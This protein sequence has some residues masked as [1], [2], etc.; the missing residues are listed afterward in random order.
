MN[1]I[2]NVAIS[3]KILIVDDDLFSIFS[4]KTML[5]TQFKLGCDFA[6]HGL[7]AIEKVIDK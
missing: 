3:N 5:E 7:E 6:Y 1:L 4:L 2:A